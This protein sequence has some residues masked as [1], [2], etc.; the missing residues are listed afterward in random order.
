MIGTK[1]KA[2]RSHKLTY[3]RMYFRV[4]MG[5]S[6]TYKFDACNYTKL[7]VNREIINGLIWK[8]KSQA[9]ARVC[10]FGI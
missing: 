10:L 8:M 1:A 7:C 6:S 4:W 5:N 3:V 9:D 2:R